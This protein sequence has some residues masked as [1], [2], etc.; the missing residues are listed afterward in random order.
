[1]RTLRV[2]DAIFLSTASLIRL[3]ASIPNSSASI[4]KYNA[5]MCKLVMIENF[6]TRKISV[7]KLLFNGFFSLSVV[8]ASIQP[9]QVY[10]DRLVHRVTSRMIIII[11][12]N[13]SYINYK[14]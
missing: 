12:S 7:M 2:S 10:E 14:K 3:T 13:D 8:L 1:M 9:L 6:T 11:L 5:A 4:V